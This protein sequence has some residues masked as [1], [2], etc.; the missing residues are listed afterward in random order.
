MRRRSWSRCRWDRRRVAPTAGR[1]DVLAEVGRAATEPVLIFGIAPGFEVV[2]VVVT[3]T[4]PPG[5]GER[6]PETSI[7][8]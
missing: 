2:A 7:L 8:L 5:T 4:R 3:P 6:F 1:A